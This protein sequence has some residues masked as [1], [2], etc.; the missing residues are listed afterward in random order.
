LKLLGQGRPWVI[1]KWAMSLDGK[2]ATKSGDSRWISNE[3]SRR[4][5][6]QLRGRI[7]AIVVGRRTVDL[8]DPLLTARPAGPRTPI[9]VVLD[10][11]GSLPLGSQLVRTVAQAPVLVVVSEKADEAKAGQ[12]AAAGCEVVRLSGSTWTDRLPALLDELGRRRLTNVLIEGGAVTLGGFC[13]LN[14]IDEFHVFVAP[15]IIGGESAP[16]PLGGQGIDRMVDAMKLDSPII[17][18]LDGDIYIHGR[19]GR[20]CSAFTSPS[21]AVI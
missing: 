16:N 21:G 13:D 3:A 14:A 18:M 6:H 7:D 4:V 12:L 19:T 9:R 15:K 11:E 5:V 1:A 8:D 17:E 20:S 10:A 2:I